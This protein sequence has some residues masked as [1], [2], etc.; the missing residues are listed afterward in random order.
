MND[1]A[2]ARSI[3]RE[4]GV[5][6]FVNSAAGGGRARTYLGQIQKLFESFQVPAQFVMTNSAVKLEL[7]AQVAISEGRR[8]LFAMGGDGTFQA[9]AN[10]A[11]GT[12]VLLGVLPLGGGNDFAAALGLPDDPVKAAEA[13]LRGH[14][15]FVDLARVRTA[16]GRTRLYAGGGGI[17]LDAEAIQYANGT[18]RHFPGRFRYIASALRA[19]AGY[20]PIDVGLEFPGSAFNPMEAK[21]LLVGV[22]NT[23]TYGAGMHL[24]PG[25]DLGD[26]LL[27]VVLIENL[28]L[29]GVLALLPG[30]IT[31]GELQTSR[32]KRWRIQR[33]R[34]T[35]ERRCLFQGDG[36]IIGPTPVEIEAAPRAIQVLAPS[37]E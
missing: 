27:D 30:L 29:F 37:M 28:S 12:D 23:P 18:F 6:V 17:G 36:E 8:A 35:T 5:I 15:R 9:L 26:G 7:S 31:S 20:V 34:L 24:A 10:A 19:L 3:L 14:P 21:A 11:F 33:V 2:E 13:L 25:A 16:E 1:R 32:V 22:L 4:S